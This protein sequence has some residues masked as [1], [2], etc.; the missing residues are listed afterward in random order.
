MPV[1]VGQESYAGTQ[2]LGMRAYCTVRR[3]ERMFRVDRILMLAPAGETGS[4]AD[5]M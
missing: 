1:S 2:F 4:A 3:D 5:G